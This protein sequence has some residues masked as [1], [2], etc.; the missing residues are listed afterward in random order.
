MTMN[1]SITDIAD[2]ARKLANELYDND[3]FAC[4]NDNHCLKSEDSRP[5][6]KEEKAQGLVRR[7]FCAYD[8]E[9]LCLGCRAYFYAEMAAQTTERARALAIMLAADKR[10]A[11]AE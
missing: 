4:A 1:R 3:S 10:L 11:V 8:A 5:L 2:D 6:T 7:P 9:R